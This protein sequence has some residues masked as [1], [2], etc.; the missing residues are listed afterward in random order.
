MIKTIH[1]II[2]PPIL[3]ASMCLAAGPGQVPLS[4]MK[5][6]GHAR[7][8]SDGYI[9]FTHNISQA[10]SAFVPTPF[11]LGPNDGFRAYFAYESHQE[12]GQCIAD[13]LA[14]V[15]QNTSAG[16]SYLGEDGSGLGFFTGTPS[17][18]VGVTFDYYA[19]DI[20]GTPANAAAI[21]TPD[22]V[23]LVWTTPHPEA[24]S[25]PDAQRYVW[26]T[27]D[28]PTKIMQVFYSATQTQPATPLLETVLPSDLSTLF[29]GQAYFG[30]TA[31]T[32][33][34]YSEQYLLYFALDVVNVQ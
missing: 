7:L 23:D 12:F 1:C 6:N 22:G 20:T 28:N 24:L 9:R 27:Y 34:C 4:S 32:G 31:G 13:G 8:L 26:V 5:L 30:V 19:N 29:G 21:A 33:S 14:F 3:F 18:A 25:G 16:A 2:L 11:P 17:P 15:A 10:S